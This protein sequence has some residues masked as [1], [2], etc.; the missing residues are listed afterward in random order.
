[1]SSHFVISFRKH[2]QMMMVEVLSFLE[3][4]DIIKVALLCKTIYTII[5]CNKFLKQNDLPSFHFKTIFEEQKKLFTGKYLSDMRQFVCISEI[6][7]IMDT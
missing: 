1:M 2:K 6:V 3:P 4:Q 5:D 7:D